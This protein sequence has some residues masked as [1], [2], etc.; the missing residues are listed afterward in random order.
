M[1]DEGRSFQDVLKEAQAKGYAE[2]DPTYD[3]EGVDA[4]HKLAILIRL[5]HG[6]PFQFKDVFINGMSEITAQDIESV[7]NSDI[8][9]SSSDPDP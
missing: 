7:G 3:V 6:T 8:A 9:S 4:A 2:A 5:A 1:T